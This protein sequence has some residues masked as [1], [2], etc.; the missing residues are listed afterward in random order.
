M[1]GKAPASTTTWKIA[2]ALGGGSLSDDVRFDPNYVCLTP[3]SGHSH[4]L[5]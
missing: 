2:V 5:G 1:L 3:N 4:D